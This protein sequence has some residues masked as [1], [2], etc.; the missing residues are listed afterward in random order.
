M[1]YIWSFSSCSIFTYSINK[2]DHY[3]ISCVN[4]FYTIDYLQFFLS[5]NLYITLIYGFG[6]HIYIYLS[7]EVVDLLLE[8]LILQNEAHIYINKRQ[9][10]HEHIY[11][12]IYVRMHACMHV[13]YQNTHLS[14]P[15]LFYGALQLMFEVAQL[16]KVNG[17]QIISSVALQTELKI[18]SFGPHSPDLILDMLLYICI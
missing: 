17:T 11:I 14:S 12:Y 8:E 7:P 10:D 3:Y 6:Q 15:N 2:A 13:G 9:S 1:W 5:P 18:V 16:F 4:N